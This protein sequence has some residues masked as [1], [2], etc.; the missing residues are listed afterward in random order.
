[1]ATPARLGKDKELWAELL[2]DERAAA[3][4]LGYSAESWENGD[5]PACAVAWLTLRPEQRAAAMALGYER[6]EWDANCGLCE[7]E[8]GAEA[9]GGAAAA[10]GTAMSQLSLQ[11]EARFVPTEAER[12]ASRLQTCAVCLETGLRQFGV[13]PN[14]THCF[15]L[16]C[17]RAWRATH[18]AKVQ[19]ARSCP[20][21]R[22][23]SHFVV[24]SAVFITQPQRKA[25]LIDSYEQN[26]RGVA[27]KHFAFGAGTCPFGSSCFYAHTDKLGRPVAS[28]PRFAL[29]ASGS[30]THVQTYR[31]SDYLFGCEGDSIDTRELLSSIPLMEDDDGDGGGG[32]AD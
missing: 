8:A 6:A 14:C 1:M 24:P 18:S 27:C 11:G 28:D 32:G 13:L 2:A 23:P 22:A 30:S 29:G 7:A 16:G 17:I 10:A 4:R 21:C 3:A 15:C 12:E 31:L 9:A 26:L 5:P 19:V 20:E 25:A